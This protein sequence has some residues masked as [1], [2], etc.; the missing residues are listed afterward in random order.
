MNETEIMTKLAET[1]QRSKANMHRLDRVEEQLADN[2]NMLASLAA[3]AQRQDTMDGDI[4][5]IKADVK[6]L[7]GKSAK[8]WDSVIEKIIIMVVAALVTYALTK[9]GFS[10]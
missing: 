8:R 3:M 5:E 1:E 9:F 6:V 7:T 4:K 2:Q 10:V